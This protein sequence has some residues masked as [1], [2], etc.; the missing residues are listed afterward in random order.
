M[1]VDEITRDSFVAAL[2]A[3]LTPGTVSTSGADLDVRST[4][5][6]RTPAPR[7]L[8]VVRP[9]D[10]SEVSIVL[11]AA[12]AAG[13]AVVPQGALTG[14]VG[15]ASAIEGALLLDLSALDRI[16]RID[17]IDRV[18]VVQPGVTVAQLQHAASEVG[19]FYAPDPAS[20]EWATI[21]GTIATNAGGMRCIKYG[22]TRN[23]VRSLEVVL[24][25]GS[26]ERT[27]PATVKGVAGLD[28]TSLIV[29]SEGTLAVVTEATLALLPAPGP[30]RG[31]LATFADAAAAFDAANVLAAGPRLPSTLEF[32]DH[33]ALTGIRMLR[34]DL[35]IAADA[36][37][38]LLA[39]TDEHIGAAGDLD[40]FEEVFRAHGAL[41]LTRADDE[42]SLERLFEA[43]RLL[44]PALNTVRGGATHGDLAV[45]RSQLPAFAE[46]TA[47]IRSTFGVEISLAGHV[48]DGNLHPTVVFDPDDPAGVE[49][50]HRAEREL[51]TLAQRL[52]GTIAGEHGVGT[53][54][55]Q[56]VDA[57]MS[58]RL[59]RLQRQMKAVFDPNGTLN[60][61]RKI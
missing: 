2:R 7:A 30:S 13:I 21:G 24:A 36:G 16:L 57:E 48:G 43:R 42:E 54:K 52:G 14:L 45:P 5:R 33:V 19:L 46:G 59:R 28:I 51:L 10:S 58:P 50:A 29:G 49:A 25:D 18:A 9:I 38:W 4:D 53:L 23:A 44:S 55:L 15:G 56:G 40:R 47:L 61:G 8:A 60:P 22:V 35:A 17:P 12:D 34:P 37:A 20:A 31:V 26:V 32:L 3:R 1:P 6:S 11:A 39:V 27:R 41:T